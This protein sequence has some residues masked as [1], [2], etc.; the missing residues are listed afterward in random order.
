MENDAVQRGKALSQKVPGKL[1]TFRRRRQG[2]V[3]QGLEDGVEDIHLARPEVLGN[4]L[5]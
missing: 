5:C 1:I 2:G 3:A 4:E